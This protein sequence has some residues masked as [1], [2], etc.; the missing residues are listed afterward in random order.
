[1]QVLNRLKLWQKLGLLVAA[2]AVPTALL[3]FFY[4]SAANHEVSQAR[5]ELDGAHY[6][7]RL[8]AVL[9][10]VSQHRSLLFALLTGDSAESGAVASS[11]ARMHKLLSEVD[12]VNATVGGRLGV[13]RQWRAIESGWAA[14]KSG[15]SK[16]TADQA[17]AQHDAL[18]ARIVGLGRLVVARSALNVDPSPQTAA[19][20]RVATQDV[21][22]ALI[23][24]GEVQWYATSAAIKGYLGGGD[25][26]AIQIYHR[27]VLEDFAQARRDLNGASHAARA[28]IQPML[29]SA[30]ASFNAS[31]DLIRRRVLS[32]HKMT[33]TT[34]ALFANSQ[35]VNAG[36]QKLL[37]ASYST[38]DAAVKHRLSQVTASRALTLGVTLAALLVAI[39]LSWF[40]ATALT[41]LITRAITVF[42]RISAGQYDNRIELNGSDEANQVLRSL[43]EMQGK[44]RAQ[45]ENERLVATENARIR[46]ALDSVSAGVMVADAGSSIIYL[47]PAAA[48]VLAAAEQDIRRDLPGFSAATIRGSSMDLFH[49]DPAH[50]RSLIEKLSGAHRTDLVLGGHAFAL[51]FNPVES[52]GERIGTVVEWKDRTQEVAV[53]KE[54]QDMLSAVTAGRLGKRIATGGKSG[55][56]EVMSSGVN[57]LAD[58]MAEVVSRVKEVAVEVHRGADEIS[59]GNANLSQRTE[60]QSSSLEETASS[61]EQMTTTVKQ[62]ADNA[63]QANQ[64]ALAAREQAEKGGTVVGQAV[65]AMSDINQAS[66][67]I[68]DII[69]VIDEIAFQTNL[70]ALNAAVEAA[71]A[72]EQGRGFAVVA[73]EVRN[74]A[75]R[76]ATAAKEIKGLI[77]DSVRKVGDGSILVTQ[78]GQTLE[79]IMAAVKKVSDIVAEI[80]AASR[81]QSSGIEQVNRAVMQ[82]DEL[83]QQNAALVEQATASSQSMVEQVRGLNETLDR[84]DVGESHGEER[85][86]AASRTAVSGRA[87]GGLAPVTAHAAARTKGARN[88]ARPPVERRKANRPWGQRAA[89]AAAPAAAPPARGAPKL[90]AVS[91]GAAEPVAT[92]DSEWQE[93]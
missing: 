58:N 33:I 37:D 87:P 83:T 24:S 30:L 61:M 13:T 69:G 3:G 59:S 1:M 89:P 64:L 85:A 36:L 16:M 39:A 2:M 88:T 73:S 80:A 75:G 65:A 18:I 76:S 71:R 68:A 4:L 49:R 77:Q 9:A 12:A 86:G 72:G 63:A 8:G 91:S 5:N 92:E 53:E 46:Q 84:F 52:E 43:D 31:F 55:F 62:N 14:L 74:L 20:I 29:R 79:K 40:M 57:R 66:K 82:M 44:L 6:A 45:I 21:P 41:A 47:N 60:E 35:S 54:M 50:Q 23:A 38:M 11:E 19:L 17:A 93:F 67:K 56:F 51:T 22:N 27:Q 32:A 70:L 48:N 81:E 26:R 25:S 10:E 15:E 7:H 90:A 28:R 42:E 34:A 78:S